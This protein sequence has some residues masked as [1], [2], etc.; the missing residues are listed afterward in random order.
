MTTPTVLLVH[1]VRAS[2]TMWRAQLRALRAAGVPALAPDL[3]GHGA[4]AG[5]AFT[6]ERALATLDDAAGAV[7]GPVVVVG[8]SM[9][10]YLALH[11]AA[12]TGRPAA[13]LAASCCTRPAGPPLWA[14]RRLAGAIARLPDGGARLGEVLARRALPAQALADV[15]AGGMSVGVMDAVLA[16]LAHIDPLADLRAVA[17]PVWLVNG[18]WDHFRTQERRF[19]RQCAAGRLVVVPGASHLVS[20][21]RPVAFNRV[22]LELVDTVGAR[23][24][25]TAGPGAALPAPARAPGPVRPVSPARRRPGAA[26]GAAAPRPPGR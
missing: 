3:P 1:G 13:V 9:G 2:A 8:L 7:G 20:L 17:V 18:R 6:V 10:G 4:R 16:G 21:V 19:L 25:P 5:E 24:T 14:Y 23:P 15:N 22:L 11:W 26:R 12:R